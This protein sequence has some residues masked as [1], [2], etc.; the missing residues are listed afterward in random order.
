MKLSFEGGFEIEYE[1]DD[2]G[3]P[4]KSSYIR[5]NADNQ[6]ITEETRYSRF[7]VYQGIL[8]PTI[9]DRFTDNKHIFRV[10]YESVE[11]NKSVP[12]NIFDKPEN[13]K[14]LKKKLKF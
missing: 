3:L 14:K 13:P 5:M 6:A 7:I 8:F 11:F 10:A 4:M 1:F 9:V 2:K 12:D